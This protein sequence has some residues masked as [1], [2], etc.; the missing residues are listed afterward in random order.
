MFSPSSA[1]PTPATVSLY[2]L[3]DG[4]LTAYPR[5]TSAAGS[6]GTAVRLLFKG[7]TAS[8]AATA[9]TEL[10][11][12]TTAPRLATGD[13]GILTVR[14]PDQ[15]SPLSRR[16]MLQLACT[17]DQAAAPLAIVVPSADAKV[18]GGAVRD[19]AWPGSLRVLGDGWTM[20]QS[21]YECPSKPQPQK[22]PQH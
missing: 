12:L 19:S 13:D 17:V 4:N 14:L 10:P 9:T 6:L 8:E 3:R 5:R 15:A 2:F 18:A 11:R 7:P 1:P 22:P 20:T 21:D 16:A